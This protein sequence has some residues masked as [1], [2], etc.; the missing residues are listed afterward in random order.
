[1]ALNVE[2]IRESFENVKPIADKVSDK[3][4]EFLWGDY[5]PSKALFEDV[6][7]ETQ[8]KALIGSLVFIVENVD[9]T[10]KLVPYLKEMGKRHVPY[11]TKEEHYPMVGGTLLKTF[12]HFF[13][14]DW[15]EELNDAWS[16]AYGVITSVML[17][18]AAE[19]APTHDDIR[20]KAKTV[21]DQLFKEILNEGFDADFEEY[22]RA[23]V[24]KSLYKIIDEES[25]D[26]FG[27]AA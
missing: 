23:K 14:D 12:A 2:L 10:D 4:Y 5:P 27:K 6:K 22:V 1:M 24:R 17:E 26:L 18:G 19:Y 20:S 11:G 21:C 7:M 9:N 8:K 25:E 3:F 16:E 15:T 13:G